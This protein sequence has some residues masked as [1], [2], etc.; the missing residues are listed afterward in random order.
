MATRVL[1]IDDDPDI[2]QSVMIALKLEG[3]E[4]IAAADAEQGYRAATIERPDLIILDVEMPGMN[5]PEVLKW[6]RQNPVSSRIPIIFLTGRV[7]LEAMEETFEGEA[8]GFLMKPFSPI[9]LLN[10]MEAVLRGEAPEE[11]SPGT[12]TAGDA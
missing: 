5:G 6:I 9:Q 4:V 1:L 3:Y 8:Q 12:A 10:K 11:G 7:D 2:R